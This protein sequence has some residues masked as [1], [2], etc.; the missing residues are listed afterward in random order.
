VL[1]QY[2][3]S[4]TISIGKKVHQQI[5]LVV[6]LLGLSSSLFLAQVKKANKLSS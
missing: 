2:A 5:F 1:A 3:T 6:A 4:V